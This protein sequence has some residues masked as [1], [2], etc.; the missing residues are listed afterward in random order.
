MGPDGRR[1]SPGRSAS[2]A[3]LGLIAAVPLGLGLLMALV[4]DGGRGAH[5]LGAGTWVVLATTAGRVP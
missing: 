2:R 4:T 1:P 3:A 5:D